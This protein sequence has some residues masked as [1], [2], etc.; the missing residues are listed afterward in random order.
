M[1]PAPPA[2]RADD[3]WRNL[4]KAQVRRR[5]DYLAREDDFPPAPIDR[6]VARGYARDDLDALP[7]PVTAGFSG[8]LN[9]IADIDLSQIDCAVDLGCGAGI[10]ALLVARALPP[11]ARLVAVDFAPEIIRR[12][13]RAEHPETTSLL[14]PVIADMESLPLADRIADLVIANASFNLCVEAELAF[15]EAYRILRPGGRIAAADFVR[16]G[17]LPPEAAQN[18]MAWNASIGGI[19]EQAELCDTIARAGFSDIVIT[20]HRAAPPVVAVRI[21]ATKAA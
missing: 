18:P 4:V 6:A 19:Q 17:P 14:T 15:G 16:R 1:A 13:A 11:G 3:D 10:D 9:P 8:S 7:G 2:R 5:Y 12:L 21:A 20:G